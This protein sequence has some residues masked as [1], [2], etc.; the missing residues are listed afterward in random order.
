MKTGRFSLIYLGFTSFF[1]QN[2]PKYEI[3]CSEYADVNSGAKVRLTFQEFEEKSKFHQN[4]QMFELFHWN[5]GES[6]GPDMLTQA[7]PAQYFTWM[8][9]RSE[10]CIAHSVRG[11]PLDSYYSFKKNT[12]LYICKSQDIFF[13]SWYDFSFERAKIKFAFTIFRYITLFGLAWI[14]LLVVGIHW[15]GGENSDQ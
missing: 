2:A 10:L 1:K 3:Y 4:A 15:S 14:H 11:S 7:V 6:L 5:P 13:A 9:H 12:R 8:D